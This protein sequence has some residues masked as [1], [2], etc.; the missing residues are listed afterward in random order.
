MSLQRTAFGTF[1]IRSRSL[2]VLQVAVASMLKVCFVVVLR[3][4]MPVWIWLQVRQ[5]PAQQGLLPLAGCS[6]AGL[7]SALTKRFRRFFGRR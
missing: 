7:S 4:L 6:P 2:H 5:R 1:C 3:K